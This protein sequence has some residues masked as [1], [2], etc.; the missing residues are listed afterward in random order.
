MGIVSRVPVELIVKNPSPCLYTSITPGGVTRGVRG[1][2]HASVKGVCIIK[3]IFKQ[4]IYFLS[5]ILSAFYIIINI[6]YI[7]LSSI[8]SLSKC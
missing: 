5:S 1:S 8:S 4:F 2:L 7:L 6:Y 3:C